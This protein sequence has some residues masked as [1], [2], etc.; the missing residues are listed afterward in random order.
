MVQNQRNRASPKA[1]AQ[2]S[3]G[4]RAT[5]DELRSDIDSGRTGEKVDHPDP[6]A[7]PLGS[8]AEAGGRATPRAD[9]ER[10]RREELRR[11]AFRREQLRRPPD[12]D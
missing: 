10:A 1:P 11:E 7:A 8:D 5:A 9:I 12:T 4:H 3:A 6:A 2:P